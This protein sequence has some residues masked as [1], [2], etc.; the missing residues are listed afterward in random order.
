MSLLFLASGSLGAVADEDVIAELAAS[1]VVCHGEKGASQNPVF[2]VLAGQHFYY[3]YVQLKD[4][5]AERRLD[6]V[7]TPIASALEKDQM[8]A[9]AEY[10]SK[11]EWPQIEAGDKDSAATANAVITAGQ[12]V[13][14]HLGGFEGDSRVPR[15]ATQHSDYLFKTM[16]D[17]KNKT[18]NNSPAKSSLFASFSD[19]ELRAVADY[20]SA[21]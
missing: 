14:C 16:V 18:R 9:L 6:P 2:P 7:M 4:F 5:K 13:A 12:C 17:F 3:L 1:C 21:Q 10:F 15:M 11:Q 20:L 8:Q 19:E